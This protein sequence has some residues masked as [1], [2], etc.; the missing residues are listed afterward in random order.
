MKYCPICGHL[1]NSNP[2]P[3]CRCVTRA[4]ADSE[5]ALN[6][7]SK[8]DTVSRIVFPSTYI[9]INIIY[10]YMYLDRSERIAVTTED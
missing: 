3:G 4:M 6:S 7:V 5:K 1:N 10:W 9:V 2:P 8:I